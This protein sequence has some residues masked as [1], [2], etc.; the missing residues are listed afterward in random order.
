MESFNPER[1]ESAGQPSIHDV[2]KRFFRQA[3]NDQLNGKGE[4]I[5]IV[6]DA[7]LLRLYGR[8]ERF[9]AVLG[10]PLAVV[11]TQ[12]GVMFWLHILNLSVSDYRR[13]PYLA[14]MEFDD[15]RW[16]IKEIETEPVRP[17]SRQ[18]SQEVTEFLSSC[19]LLPQD[20]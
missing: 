5:N 14:A 4:F 7:E 6:G 16:Y 3:Y 20:R 17:Y 8:D 2:C 10:R 13:I 19:Y 15:T 18:K 1:H 12:D 9:D 11:A